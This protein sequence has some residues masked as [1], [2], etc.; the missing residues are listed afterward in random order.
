M[1]SC[2][3]KQVPLYQ[4]PPY[5][6]LSYCWGVSV[7]KIPIKLN[8]YTFRVTSN[9]HA[10]LLRL[11]QHNARYKYVWVDA[12]CINQG[13][14]EE[15]SIQI[16]R[17]AAIY[18][19]AEHV[20]VWLGEASD[21][22]ATDLVELKSLDSKF[23]STTHTSPS[24]TAMKTVYQLL[25]R[26]YWGRMWIIQELAAAS[27]I[28]LLCGV[29][30]IPWKVICSVL[31]TRG[32]SLRASQIRMRDDA[33]APTNS[34]HLSRFQKIQSFVLDKAARKPITLVEALYRSRYARSTDPKDKLYALLGL[35]YDG[36]NFIPHPNYSL[37][38][39]EAYHKFSVQ[40]LK[41]GC[42]LDFIVLRSAGRT[43]DE[44]LPS[45]AVDWNDLNDLLARKE[46]RIIMN[47]PMESPTPDC[48]PK[49]DG[50]KLSVNGIII[51]NIRTATSPFMDYVDRVV[52]ERKGPPP[53]Q[54]SVPS[55]DVVL[56][57]IVSNNELEG[58]IQDTDTPNRL[59]W[60][61]ASAAESPVQ[62]E[63]TNEV[64][65][66]SSSE[67]ARTM[68]IKRWFEEN[69][70]RIAQIAKKERGP[71]LPLNEIRNLHRHEYCVE[72]IAKNISIGMQLALVGNV[73]FG[74][75]HP[76]CR[77]GD[78]V[79]MIDGCSRPAALRRITSNGYR[80][81]GS[82][83]I[84]GLSPGQYQLSKRRHQFDIF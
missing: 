50:N 58:L 59:G 1:V 9:L 51:G 84:Y 8:R 28:S 12:L 37:T 73:V 74:C 63:T 75:V 17:M 23:L 4:A 55:V 7:N 10:A 20:V 13:D 21:I 47:N 32:T 14:K 72:E 41:N 45:W 35:V 39:G 43:D 25:A 78:V 61:T 40:L 44:S 71:R 54:P 29:H 67:N 49:I 68:E 24:N 26:E 38:K 5:T 42:P 62:I 66:P 15:R 48:L 16:G 52:H 56:D 70:P 76:K 57:T 36:A 22:S 34:E 6:A 64:L 31:G 60:I 19:Q 27:T 11:R 2:V 80:V 30:H 53:L 65:H 3:I 33:L 82:A 79:A 81:V 83:F 69:K 46:F 77:I 18:R